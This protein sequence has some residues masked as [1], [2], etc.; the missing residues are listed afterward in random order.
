[1]HERG[2]KEGTSRYEKGLDDGWGGRRGT[3]VSESRPEATTRELAV[4]LSFEKPSP[5]R[6]SRLE[7]L[8][9]SSTIHGR[10]TGGSSPSASLLWL[11]VVLG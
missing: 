2:R 1:M 6:W 9:G 4:I 11:N 3:E 10:T 5:A 8:S 7:S